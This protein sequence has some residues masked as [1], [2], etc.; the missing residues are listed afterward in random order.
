MTVSWNGEL[1][2]KP[3]DSILSHGPMTWMIWGYSNFRKPP[4]YPSS[5]ISLCKCPYDH[6]IR[7]RVIMFTKHNNCPVVRREQRTKGHPH[8]P[9]HGAKELPSVEAMTRSHVQFSA[10]LGI[11]LYILLFI[12]LNAKMMIP[13]DNQWQACFVQI[14]WEQQTSFCSRSIRGMEAVEVFTAHGSMPV[15]WPLSMANVQS[16]ENQTVES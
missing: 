12:H 13:N 5:W 1:K 6:T 15:E 14:S 16:R 10:G 9:E 7:L 3:L 8:I 2:R 4:Y 11:N